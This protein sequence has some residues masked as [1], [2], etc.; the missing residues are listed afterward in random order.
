M[1]A[2]YDNCV[3]DLTA[4]GMYVLRQGG[5]MTREQLVEEIK[6]VPNTVLFGV[7][8]FWTGVDIPGPH[9][10]NVII[11]KIP[12]P[13]PTPLSEAQQEIYD[14]WNRGKPRNRQRNYFAD[15]TIPEVAIKLQQGFG[16]LIRHRDDSG[17]VVL[18]DPRL[19]TKRYGQTLLGS[20][21]DCKITED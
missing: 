16:R 15:R 19:S 12:F 17:I 8:S 7:D 5:G 6:Q 14:V 21:P 18:M 11:P 1:K 2:L 4:R 3:E 20:L 13:P 10:Q 9:L